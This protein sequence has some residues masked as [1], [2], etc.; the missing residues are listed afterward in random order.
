MENDEKIHKTTKNRHKM[1]TKG[2]K[3]TTKRCKMTKN[4][5]KMT[6]N[7][8]KTT[9]MRCKTTTVV[10]QRSQRR[11]CECTNVIGEIRW[12]IQNVCIRAVDQCL[13][14]CMLLLVSVLMCLFV[15][16]RLCVF[17][18]VCLC[19]QGVGVY[20]G[21]H[22]FESR[23]AHTDE[24]E[25][26]LGWQRGVLK[27][28]GLIFLAP[29]PEYDLISGQ[30][31]PCRP[32]WGM[33]WDRKRRNEGSCGADL[34]NNSSATEQTWWKEK[35]P[36]HVIQSCS[37]P[38]FDTCCHD[39]GAVC[40][41]L[42]SSYCIAKSSQCLTPPLHHNAAIIFMNERAR[43]SVLSLHLNPPSTGISSLRKRAGRGIHGTSKTGCTIQREPSD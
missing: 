22:V 9:K 8:H 30:A 34:T 35:T 10:A 21:E 38:Q 29:S 26:C 15:S 31:V 24:W 43:W 6:K 28:L 18:L 11:V 36:F 19:L 4:R 7:R 13:C 2:H 16:L 32:Q 14:I 25:E 1:T 42:I 3:V 39:R 41:P 23:S 17:G 37:I 20:I 40:S 12:S 27:R 5:C 33:A